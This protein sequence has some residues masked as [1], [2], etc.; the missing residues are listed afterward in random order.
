[1]FFPLSW[2]CSVAYG[3]LVPWPGIEPM[4]PAVE[5]QSL[6]HWTSKE[7]PVAHVV[8]SNTSEKNE[9]WSPGVTL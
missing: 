4:P 7:V 1:M 5:V 2:P 8:C 6:N 9:G 3:I